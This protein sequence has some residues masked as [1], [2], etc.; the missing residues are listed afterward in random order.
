MHEEKYETFQNCNWQLNSNFDPE[1]SMKHVS[2]IVGLGN[3]GFQGELHNSQIL[4]IEGLIQ[5]IF[6]V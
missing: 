3:A 4:P 1:F 5:Y 6:E 2:E